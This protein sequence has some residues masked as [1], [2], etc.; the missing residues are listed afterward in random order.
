MDCIIRKG[1][2][3]IKMNRRFKKNANSLIRLHS[4]S[5][6]INFIIEHK[7]NFIIENIHEVFPFNS[8]EYT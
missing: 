7:P 1:H 3:Y 4:E 5:I 2:S 8:Q 6:T